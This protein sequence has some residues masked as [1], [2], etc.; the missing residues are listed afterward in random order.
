MVHHIFRSALVN[1]GAHFFTQSPSHADTKDLMGTYQTL[2]TDDLYKTKIFESKIVDCSEVNVYLSFCLSIYLSIYLFIYLFIYL[3]F[4]LS[5]DRS[6]YLSAYP[7]IIIY[8]S[9]LISRYIYIYIYKYVS[10][11]VCACSC[12]MLTQTRFVQIHCPT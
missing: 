12:S 9:L 5:I 10:I 4:Y 7:S 3:S 1:V 11:R 2:R 8:L 6:I